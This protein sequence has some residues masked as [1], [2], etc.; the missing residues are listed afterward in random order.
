MAASLGVAEIFK[1]IVGVAEEVA[2]LMDVSQFSLFEMS[3]DFADLGPILPVSI[4]LPNT[5][6]VGA[7]AIGNGVA[8]LLSQLPLEGRLHVVD[9]QEYGDENLGTC[10]LM[11]PDGWVGI[12]KAGRLA[13]WLRENCGLEVSGEQAL[14]KDALSGDAVRSVAPRL[15]INGLDDVAARHD[16]QLVWP[17]IMIDGGI[18]DVGA[19]V[20][21]HRLD[22]RYLACLRCAFELPRT[23]HVAAQEV[24]TG[25]PASSLADPERLLTERDILAAAP[26]KRHLLEQCLRDGKTIC[27]VIADLAKLGVTAEAGFRPSVPFVA[28]TAAALV[29]AE[30]VKALQFPAEGYAQ[31][32]IFGNVFL[33]PDSTAILNRPASASCLCVTRR[34]MI[35]T[36]RARRACG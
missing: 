21:Q 12:A 5:L 15:V 31:S 18:S 6:L 34:A 33:G 14:V 22:D 24:I 19:A 16:T 10:V 1:R 32:F 25:L 2:P 4:A 36:L 26:E 3:T 20:V 7:G 28:T 17:D 23:D 35:Q 30:L 27:S 8:L 9:K 11:E 13:A 29:V